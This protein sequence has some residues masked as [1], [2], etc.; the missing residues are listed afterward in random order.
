MMKIDPQSW[1]RLSRLLDQYL[2]LPEELREGWVDRLP[3]EDADVRPLLQQLIAEQRNDE[4]LSTLPQIDRPAFSPGTIIGPYRLI[5]ELGQGGMGVVWLAERAD[6]EVKRWVA[7]KLPLV[8]LHN[9]TLV[10]RFARE[11]DILAQL[12]HHQIARLYD[13]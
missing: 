4:F 11:R 6:G 10:E 9:Q 5:R 3:P 2:E 7:L 1:P 8:S 13:A 12:T